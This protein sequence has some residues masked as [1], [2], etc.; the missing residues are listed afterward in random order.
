[1]LLVTEPG[2]REREVR[3]EG[4]PLTLG[5]APDNGL[6]IADARVSRHHGRF[7]TRNG[8]L[9]YTDLASTNG[10]RVNGI[11]VDEIVLGAGDRLQ[12]GSA[13]VVVEHLP[14]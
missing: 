9:V 14:G 10:T 5:R 3:I 2:G 8:T 13:V 12:V 7:Q 1:M 4:Q 6:V 11:R